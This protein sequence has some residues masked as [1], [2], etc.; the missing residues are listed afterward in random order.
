MKDLKKNVNTEWDKKSNWGKL[1][2]SE[3]ANKLSDK[4]KAGNCKTD[5]M[6]LYTHHRCL[7]KFT[8]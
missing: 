2:S 5:E 1:Y 6:C 8:A 7:V 4:V 3:S